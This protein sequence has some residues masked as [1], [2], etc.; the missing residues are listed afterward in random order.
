MLRECVEIFN[1]I[2]L[3]QGD[4]LIT[5]SYELEQGDYFIVKKDGNFEHIKIEK[6]T[7]SSSVEKYDYLSQRDYYS[8][9]LDM[10][11]PID[12]KKQIHSNN[13]LSFFI[14]NNVLGEKKDTL[15]EV[16]KKYY[17]ILKN[18]LLKYDKGD[19]KSV[20]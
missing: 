4:K 6:D 13:Y 12:G 8:K 2:Y 20:V 17:E 1:K 15:D 11:K 9:L 3:E 5:D 16:I 7:T 10:N 14:K 19:R 18:P